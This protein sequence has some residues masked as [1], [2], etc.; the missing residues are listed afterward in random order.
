MM[1]VSLEESVI[2]KYFC[3]NNLRPLSFTNNGLCTIRQYRYVDEVSNLRNH[4]YKPFS[5]MP[6][7]HIS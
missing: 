4:T 3:I 5:R 1:F 2:N 6:L 7:T